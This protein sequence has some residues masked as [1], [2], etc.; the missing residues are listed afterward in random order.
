MLDVSLCT[1]TEC[2][3]SR[4]KRHTVS[5]LL[6]NLDNGQVVHTPSLH[7]H[8]HNSFTGEDLSLLTLF[9]VCYFC[10]SFYKRRQNATY[11][12]SNVHVQ[13]MLEISIR[14]AV[15]IAMLTPQLYTFQR[16]TASE[17]TMP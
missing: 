7:S 11:A 17:T 8:V 14:M 12:H 2:N 13:C 5:Y 9:N 6:T 16:M 4:L 1:L 15:A 10:V 3:L